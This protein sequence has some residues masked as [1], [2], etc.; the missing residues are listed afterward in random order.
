MITATPRTIPAISPLDKPLVD[1]WA[2][3]DEVD[4]AGG[5]GVLVGRTKLVLI[6]EP[7]FVEVADVDEVEDA[8]LDDVG[9]RM[10]C[11]ASRCAQSSSCWLVWFK[12]LSRERIDID[13]AN[14]TSLAMPGLSAVWDCR[15]CRIDEE[16]KTLSIL[17]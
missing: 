3:E 12:C 6:I 7:W 14:H 4:D 1:V 16:G 11:R 8:K 10:I 5:L 15:V 17:E 9:C 13:C 2:I